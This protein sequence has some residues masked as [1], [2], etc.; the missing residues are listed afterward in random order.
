MD[1]LLGD[2]RFIPHPVVL[3]GRFINITKKGLKKIFHIDESKRNSRKELLAG[4]LLVCIVL[5]VSVVVPMAV[6]Y[7]AERIHHY[8][9]IAIE[10]FWCFQLLATKSLYTESMK[11]YQGLKIGI[12]EGRT[13]VS[14]IVGRDTQALDEEGVIKAAVETV[15]ENT[16]DGVVAPLLFML[17][18]G[19]PGGFFY[20]AV[21]TMDSMVGYKNDEYLYLGRCAAKLDDVVNYIPARISAVF[22]ICASL[23]LKLDVKNAWQIFRRDRKK[24][25]SPNSAQTE[26]VCAGALNVQLAGD[27]YYFGKLYKKEFIG[28]FNRQ[29]EPEDIKKANYLM[30]LTGLEVWIAGMVLLWIAQ[31]FVG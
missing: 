13:A 7:L 24:H 23:F 10:C 28:D 6:L 15:A 4:F 30:I 9:R 27:A 25:A 31:S 3:I 2:P 18:F 26:S 16:S 22:M 12:N 14:M 21:N 17:L 5:L 1:L 8:I 19:I 11:V 29:I 20:K